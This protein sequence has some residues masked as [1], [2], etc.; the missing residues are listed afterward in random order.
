MIAVT[1]NGK[2][3]QLEDSVSLERFLDE[4][5]VNTK[6][7]AVAYNGNVLQKEDYSGIV[8]NEGDVLEIVQPVGGG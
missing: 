8:L 2:P 5:N 3:V 7:V 6:F 1:I 4:R